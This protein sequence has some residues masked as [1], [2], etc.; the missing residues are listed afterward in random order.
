MKRRFALETLLWVL[1]VASVSVFVARFTAPN[2]IDLVRIACVIKLYFLGAG[3]IVAY[4]NAVAFGAGN[5]VRP[6]WFLLAAGLAASFV[7]QTMLGFYQI[8]GDGQA[9]FPSPADVFFIAAYP[10]FAVALA[11]FLRACKSSGFPI[12]SQLHLLSLAIGVVF[13]LAAIGYPVLRPIFTAD[14]PPLE[15]ALNIAYPMLDFV[16]LAPTVMLLRT[17]LR[18]RGGR[19]WTIWLALAG[20]FL[21][22]FAADALFAYSEWG[23]KELDPLVHALYLACYG[24]LAV[25]VVRQ[26]RTLAS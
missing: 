13:V 26:R 4:R 25:G 18:L 22:M 1:I 24:L 8:L 7:G 21:C 14:K 16:I 9:P 20:A 2:E 3:A 23:V 12:D 15:K 17:A 10:L 6:A 11:G 19:I 5:P